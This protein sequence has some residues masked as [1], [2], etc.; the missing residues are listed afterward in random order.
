MIQG[1]EWIVIIVIVVVLFIWGPEKLPKLA[2]SFG[3]AKREFEK[4]S[5]E[6][7]RATS[8]ESHVKEAILTPSQPPAQ[9]PQESTQSDQLLE[10]ARVLGISTE[11]KTREEIANEISERLKSKAQQ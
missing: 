1:L 2:R 8:V 4:A 9:Q 7:E 11:G 5:R 3:Q 10:A 6:V